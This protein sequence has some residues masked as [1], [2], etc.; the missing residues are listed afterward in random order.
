MFS[1][2]VSWS[3]AKILGE[4]FSPTTIMFWRFLIASIILFPFL[5]L[6]KIDKNK[7]KSQFFKIIL[8][9]ILLCLYNYCYFQGTRI[10]LAGIG[11]VLVT[12]L[13]PVITTILTIIFFRKKIELNIK[14]GIIFGLISGILLLKIWNYDIIQLINNGNIYFL[15]GAFFWSILTFLTQNITKEINAIIYSIILFSFSAIFILIFIPESF[16]YKIFES[17]FRFWVHFLSVTIF[18][19]A[20]GTV[21]YFYAT[22][23]LGATISSSFTFLVPVSAIIFSIMLLDEIPDNISWIGCIMAIISVILINYK[24]T[25]KVK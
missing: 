21:A 18:A 3:N 2:G 9:S 25:G 23:E 6:L 7:I 10:G 5:F 12:T 11:G 1:W 19:M 8:A 22:Q 17:E 4:Y 24:S 16:D 20:F 13:M 14:I 15:L